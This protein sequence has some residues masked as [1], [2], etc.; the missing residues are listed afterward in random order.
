MPIF[1]SDGSET[2]PSM[3]AVQADVKNIRQLRVHDRAPFFFA[4]RSLRTINTQGV[5]RKV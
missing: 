1:V 4:I 5:P 2:S 3:H